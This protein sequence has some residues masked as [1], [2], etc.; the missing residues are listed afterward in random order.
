[1][2]YVQYI[3]ICFKMKE[4]FDFVVPWNFQFIW[5]CFGNVNRKRRKEFIPPVFRNMF[6]LPLWNLK[7]RYPDIFPWTTAPGQLPAMKLPP[8]QLP[9]RRF[10]PGQLSLSN[11]PL[12]NC[13]KTIGPYES[14]PRSIIPRTLTLD[15]YPPP[16][17]YNSPEDNWPLGFCF[18]AITS[19]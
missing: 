2:K 9:S 18:R 5:T 12:D 1:M 16:P 17:P 10:S 4:I 8:G 19:E 13:P 7:L 3:K 14:F 15:N 6:L 11:P